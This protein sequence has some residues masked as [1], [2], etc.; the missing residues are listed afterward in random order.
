MSERIALVT[1]G[2]RGLGKNAALKLAA[3]GT[4]IVLTYNRS[5]QE[6]LDVVHEI[7]EKGVN[8]A[9]LQL[10]VGDITSFDHFARQLQETLKTVWQRETFDYLLNNA[11]TGLYAPYTGTTE[12]QFDDALNIH[13]KGPFF[14]T[15]CLLPLLRDGGRILNVSSGLT[16]FTQP[17]SGTYAAMKGAMEV[18]TRFWL[19]TTG[20]TSSG[21]ERISTSNRCRSY[22]LLERSSR[23]TS[24]VNRTHAS[25]FNFSN[26]N[27]AYAGSYTH[28]TICRFVRSSTNANELI[29]RIL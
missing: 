21:S 12:A 9:A 4:G 16:R 15:Q 6:A 11:G 29:F 14:L 26:A 28:C 24:A 3:D 13:F 19:M 20:G 1:G 22:P 7:Q 23:I 27:R 8:A 25:S 10:N 2:S 18:L 5:Q 17:G